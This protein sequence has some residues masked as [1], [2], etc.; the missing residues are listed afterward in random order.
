MFSYLDWLSEQVNNEPCALVCDCYV[1]YCSQEVIDYANSHDI[2]IIV[3]LAG[4][5]GKYQPLDIQVFSILKTHRC[6]IFE[7]FYASNQLIEINKELGA[8]ILSQAWINISKRH[9]K[10]G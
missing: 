3:I 7:R 4:G 10:S 1:C 2:S 5:L 6:T 9:I 8:F